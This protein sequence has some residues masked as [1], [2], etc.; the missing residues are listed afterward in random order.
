MNGCYVYRRAEPQDA[1]ACLELRTR[2]R[3]N[4]LS[5]AQLQAIGVTAE[6]WRAGIGD[7]TLPGHVC[8]SG[9]RL[10][11]YCFAISNT[12]EIAVLAVLPEHEG[13]GVGRALLSSTVED[14]RCLGF[15]RVFLGCSSNPAVR[16]YGFYRHLGWRST[17]TFDAAHDEVLELWLGHDGMT[18][19]VAGA[20]Q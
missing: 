11:G 15:D 18:P 3:E 10:I 7:G 5:V 1:A 12:G 13:N 20:A 9:G 6:S 8:L 19:V 14:L 17:G 2:T 4:A 16:S